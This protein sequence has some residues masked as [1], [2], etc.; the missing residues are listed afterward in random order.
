MTA[1]SHRPKVVLPV[2]IQS[3][4]QSVR[5][6]KLK[7][8]ACILFGFNRNILYYYLKIALNKQLYKRK[9]IL[10]WNERNSLTFSIE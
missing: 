9:Q 1:I 10:M 5:K 3:V 6:E 4:G 7:Q 8:C 2:R